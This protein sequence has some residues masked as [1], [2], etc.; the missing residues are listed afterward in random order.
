M[1]PSDPKSWDTQLAP[2]VKKLSDEDKQLLTGYL[3]RAKMGEAFGGAP[4]P[5][6]TTVSQGIERQ[7]DWLA[8]QEAQQAEQARLK[9][10]VEA[11][12]A[13]AAAE[14]SK[15]VV[16]AFL[17]QH[18]VP[19]DVYAQRYSDQ[20]FIDVAVQNASQKSIKGVKA[21]LVFKNTFGETIY[22]SG[23]TIEQ[24]IEPGA[25]ATW[26]GGH[27]LNEFKDTD[28]KLMN[29]QEGSF[30]AEIRPTMVVFADGTSIGS[31]N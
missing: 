6:G 26:E 29:L 8:K 19:K 16:L 17:S 30:T 3:M 24:S 31:V 1:I 10:E 4:I 7:K 15:S 13:A 22:T 5:V 25:R 18:I 14:V 27:E 12:K 2:E 23:L 28:K 21:D 11:Q 20:F 9:K